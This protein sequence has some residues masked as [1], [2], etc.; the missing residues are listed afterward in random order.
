MEEPSK[1]SRTRSLKERLLSRK[2]PRAFLRDD[3]SLSSK[4]P[5]T[6]DVTVVAAGDV[7][8]AA[9]HEEPVVA[10]ED[11]GDVGVD[12]KTATP[13]SS[14]VTRSELQNIIKNIYWYKSLQQSFR[15]IFNAKFTKW[16]RSLCCP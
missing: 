16:T 15:I 14:T 11:V 7:I 8:V 2:L 1:H 13:S 5:P 4:K 10:G 6:I 3:R 9:T 12:R